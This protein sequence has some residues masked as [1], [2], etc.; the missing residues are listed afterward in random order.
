MT[1]SVNSNMC[2]TNVKFLSNEVASN[3]I[4]ITSV[5]AEQINS[6]AQHSSA[7]SEKRE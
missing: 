6:F 4:N 5:F 3:T 1:R 2:N 7:L